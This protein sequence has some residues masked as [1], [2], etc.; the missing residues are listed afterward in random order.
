MNFE[1]LFT[2]YNVQ[3]AYVDGR[4]LVELARDSLD[5]PTKEEMF[6]C[7]TNKGEVGKLVK[8]PTRMFK[9]PEGPILAAI[10]I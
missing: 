6:D 2:D 1:K 9:G 4:Q 5:K 8:V 7:V 10:V 3:L